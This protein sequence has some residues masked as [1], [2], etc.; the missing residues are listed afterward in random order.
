M[1]NNVEIAKQLG[2]IK[3]APGIVRRI[4]PDVESLPD[5]KVIILTTGSQ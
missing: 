2:Y 1:I 4:G 5:H 3:P